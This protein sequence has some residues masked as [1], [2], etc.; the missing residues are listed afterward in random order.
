MPNMEANPDPTAPPAR[1]SPPDPTP[2]PTRIR[3]QIE[4]RS[5]VVRT[6]RAE[7]GKVMEKNETIQA[8]V[9]SVEGALVEEY[10]V[11]KQTG[12]WRS[13]RNSP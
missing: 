8:Q 3:E 6:L 9:V 13:I 7:V 1:G 10:E 5:E 11:V 12:E 4:V 2:D